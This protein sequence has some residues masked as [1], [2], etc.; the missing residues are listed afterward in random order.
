MHSPNVVCLITCN[1]YVIGEDNYI[2]GTSTKFLF[3]NNNHK[4]FIRNNTPGHPVAN[5]FNKNNHAANDLRC[6]I[7]KGH[8]RYDRER[9]LFEQKLIVKY[10]FH[11]NSLDKDKS[12]LSNYRALS[13]I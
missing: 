4:A 9:Q 2:G 12:F 13:Y 5:H 8:F 11:I 7:L 6:C 1:N 10:N 3:R